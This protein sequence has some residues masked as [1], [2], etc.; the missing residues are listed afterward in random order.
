MRERPG[1]KDH[2]QFSKCTIKHVSGGWTWRREFLLGEFH[3]QR[4]LPGFNPWGL[5]ESDATEHARTGR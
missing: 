3:G 5:K 4:S 2:V 1:K